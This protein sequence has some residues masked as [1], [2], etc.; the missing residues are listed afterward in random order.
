MNLST[1]TGINES[2]HR[3]TL[4]TPKKLDGMTSVETLVVDDGSTAYRRGRSQGR[5]FARRAAHHTRTL[6]GLHRRIDAALRLGATS[7]STQTRQSVQRRGHR[8]PRRADRQGSAEVVTAIARW[9]SRSTCR[10]QA[11][12]QRLAVG[13]SGW[14]PASASPTSPAGSRLL[15]RCGAADQRLQSLH[16]H[17]RN[18]IQSGNRNSACSVPCTNAPTRPSRLYRGIGTYLRKSMATIFRIYTLYKP[19]RRSSPSARC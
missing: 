13:P 1:N 14:R 16:L 3:A 12:A 11:P 10:R 2:R 15:A 19:L 7:S 4:A 17:A 5:R 9:R 18:V 6:R 8:A